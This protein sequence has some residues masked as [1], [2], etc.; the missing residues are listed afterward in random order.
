M[1]FSNPANPTSLLNPMNPASPFRPRGG[2]SSTVKVDPSDLE[3]FLMFG[4]AFAAV[5]FCAYVVWRI[6]D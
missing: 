6:W 2:G 4:I 5:A 1:T 3:V